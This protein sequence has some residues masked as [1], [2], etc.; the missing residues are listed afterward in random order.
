[1]LKTLPIF[2]V[3]FVALSGSPALAQCC[4]GG[5]GSPIAGGTS[6]GVLQEK[7]MEVNVNYQNIN[8]NK[9][10][11]GDIPT[12]TF[13]AHYYSQYL[14]GRVAY[15]VTKNFTM[16][17]ESGYY[18]NKTQYSPR[19]QDTISSHG[20]ADLV[21]FPRYDIYN[22]TEDDKT[23]E[24]TVGLGY[25]IPLG[26]SNDSLIMLHKP[27]GEDIYAPKP[28]VLQPSSGS[29]DI[30]FYGFFF[31][32][33]PLK[34]FRV[35]ANMLYI[36]KGWNAQGEKYGDYATVGLFASKTLFE[37]LGVTLQLKGEW[38]DRMHVVKNFSVTNGIDPYATGSKKVSIV[39]Q[40]SFPFFHDKM[41]VYVMS[42]FPIWQYVNKQQV[43]SQY[44]TTFGVSY[45]FFTY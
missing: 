35:F 23:T 38:I 2:M 30:I 44:N 19:Y 1:M 5:G 11:D 16:S 28:L 10:L 22:K 12:S 31:R 27:S 33:Y 4:G 45:R 43:A 37:K 8:T 3:L 14:Y 20:I 18:L 6:Q 9:F 7:Q 34:K 39:P 40:L 42:E 15:G 32:G 24:V 25:K 36:M 17:L 21:I 41:S 13:L 26:V 29:Q